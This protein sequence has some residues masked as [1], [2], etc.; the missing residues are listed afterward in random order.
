MSLDRDRDDTP[1]T[2]F[3]AQAQ[4]QRSRRIVSRDQR[5]CIGGDIAQQF[6]EAFDGVRLGHT[7]CWRARL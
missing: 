2:F 1:R 6:R 5:A 4:P 3:E 7:R